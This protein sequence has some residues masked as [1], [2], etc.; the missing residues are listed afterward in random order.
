ME[1]PKRKYCQTKIV[2]V[3]TASGYELSWKQ[4]GLPTDHLLWALLTWFLLRKNS[5]FLLFRL[6][7]QQKR[8]ALQQRQY[9]KIYRCKG[10]PFGLQYVSAH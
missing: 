1:C 9:V 7:F 10:A 8:L 5:L 2:E 6:E 4:A 3:G